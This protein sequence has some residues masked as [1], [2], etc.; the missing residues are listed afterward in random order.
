MC[1]LG[2]PG[3]Y[4]IDQDGLKLQR[5]AGLCPPSVE[6]KVLHHQHPASF[7]YCMYLFIHLARGRYSHMYTPSSDK[8][9]T[10]HRSQFSLSSTWV[11]GVE[12]RSL[13]LT[14]STLATDT[15][16]WPHIEIFIP[17]VVVVDSPPRSP[18]FHLLLYLLSLVRLMFL[19]AMLSSSAVLFIYL[20]SIAGCQSFTSVFLCIYLCK[21]YNEESTI[22]WQHRLSSIT[23]W[24]MG[25]KGLG[26]DGFSLPYVSAMKIWM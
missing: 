15:L 5:S 1:S 18:V 13:G 12:T 17:C 22:E 2:C 3:S 25:R 9:K 20:I 14:A 7:F 11:W 4:T 24:K 10:S 23:V 8:Q 26:S 21:Y 16:F 19:F 6:I